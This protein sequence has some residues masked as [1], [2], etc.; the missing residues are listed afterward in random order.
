MLRG[1]R[2]P[3]LTYENRAGWVADAR[4]TRR[5]A[6]YADR[7]AGVMRPGAGQPALASAAGA[8]HNH[9]YSVNATGVSA[10][11]VIARL[12]RRARL[13]SSAALF[14]RVPE[15]GFSGR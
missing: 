12:D 13:A 6:G 9:Y 10:D 7:I 14:D 4:A 3:E 11:E 2:G 5:L 8:T 1:E 15:T